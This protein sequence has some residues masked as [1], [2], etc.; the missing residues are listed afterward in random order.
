MNNGTG[1]RL[2]GRWLDKMVKR[3]LDQSSSD[4]VAAYLPA[5]R[6]PTYQ[7]GSRTLDLPIHVIVGEHDGA[8]NEDFMR[9]TWLM[10]YPRATLEVMRNAGHYPMDETPVALA[11]SVERFLRGL[12]EL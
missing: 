7:T 11:T 8:L 5:W 6:R 12:P 4:A 10:H 9:Q 3:S 1:S 2:S